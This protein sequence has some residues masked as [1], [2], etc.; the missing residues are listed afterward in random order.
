[1][2]PSAFV[3]LDDPNPKKEKLDLAEAIVRDAHGG[4]DK[5]GSWVFGGANTKI[6]PLSFNAVE[7]EL[8]QQRRLDREE[9]GMVY[10]MAGPLMGDL[11]HATFSNVTEMLRSLYRDVIPPWTELI[12]QTAQAQLID[13]ESSWIN[14]YIRFSFDDKLKGDPTEQASVDRSDVEAGIRTRDEAREGRGLEPMGG[15]ADELT[16][17]T[18]NQAPVTSMSPAPSPTASPALPA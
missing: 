11:E 8:I 15:Q 9:I 5:S 6:T 18:N 7:V 1:V 3:S 16:A 2:R 4:M 10:D 12:V 13:P 14:R 17:N